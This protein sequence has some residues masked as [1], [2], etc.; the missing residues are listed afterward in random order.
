[1]PGDQ[2]AI[3]MVGSQADSTLLPAPIAQAISLA[4]RSTQLA[5]RVTSIFGTYT[6]STAKFTT[7]SSLELARG[8]VEGVLI[9]AGGETALGSPYAVTDA[10]GILERS[11]EVLHHAVSHAAF[12]TS[13]S[14]QLTGTTLSAV[15][16]VSTLILSSLDQILGSTDSSRAIASIVTLIRREFNNGQE[17]VGV[18]DLVLALSALAYLQGAC[19]KELDSERKTHGSEEIIWDVVVVDDGLRIDVPGTEAPKSPA[20]SPPAESALLGAEDEDERTLERL[21]DEIKSSL[22][23]GTSVT[24]SSSVSTTQTITLD[25]RGPQNVALPTVAGAEIVE[26]TKAN[27]NGP[28]STD[29]SIRVVYKIQRNKLRQTEL[30]HKDDGIVV[31]TPQVIEVDDAGPPSPALSVTTTE[32]SEPRSPTTTRSPAAEQESLAL[33][34]PRSKVSRDLTRPTQASARRSSSAIDHV[35]RR[36]SSPQLASQPVEAAN[37]KRTRMPSSKPVTRATSETSAAAKH[38]KK[39]LPS[40]PKESDKKTGFKQVL[41]GGSQSISNIWNREPSA[42][43]NQGSASRS[44]GKSVGANARGSSSKLQPPPFPRNY[45]PSEQRP[46]SCSGHDVD[47]EQIQRSSSRASYVSVHERRRDSMVSQTDSYSVHAGGDLR[48]ASPSILRTEVR[49]GETRSR[50]PNDHPPSSTSPTMTHHRRNGSHVPSLYSLAGNDSQSSLVLSSYFQKSA[51]RSTDAMRT[52]RQ[53]GAVEGTFPSTHLLR[54]ISRYMRFSSASYGSNFLKLLG[55]SNDMPSLQKGDEPHD[56]IRHFLH[57]TDSCMGNVLLASFVDAGG[58]SDAQGH[59]DSGMPLVHYISL[60]H[61]AKAVVLACR[62]TLGFEDILADLTC[63]YD[64]LQWRGRSH[65]VHKGVLASARRILYGYDGRVLVTLQEALKEFPEYGLV[66]CGHSLGGAVTSLLGVMLSEPNPHGT[67][68][69][70]TTTPQARYMA[71][72]HVDDKLKLPTGRPIHVFAYGPPGAM[73]ATLSKL[74]KGLITTVVHGSDVVPHLSLG[75]LHDFQAMAVAFKKGDNTAKTDIRQ[76]IWQAFQTNVT[77][78]LYNTPVPLEVPDTDLFPALQTLRATLSHEKLLPPG[79]VFALE[80]QR[81][82]RRDAFLFPQENDFGQ[83]ARRMVLTYVKDVEARFGEV[84][85]GTGMLID[86]SP[87][88]YEDALERLRRGVVE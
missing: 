35:Q 36:P 74:T 57:H 53:A 72:N 64:Q 18:T 37:Q 71:G 40:P 31:S 33:P 10:E 42:A 77:G 60:D 41:R 22:N 68:F 88:K 61:E 45:R 23:P 12:W 70:T 47:P 78:R 30:E 83:P 19:R 32:S 46:A 66:L 27:G 85:F 28:D 87:K 4:T 48:P 17:K 49:G 44:Q 15:S 24:I 56:D 9:R 73:S 6:L 80:T 20:T 63:D 7:L 8:I 76:R 84:R 38:K 59:T 82:L 21:K 55:I 1:M 2:P 11:L 58:G 5:I 81:V 13:A 86:H 29:P 25:V 34:K 3:A 69:V 79:E 67:G 62:G 16:D 75:L 39:A 52:L 54:N 43:S 14:F 51:Y 50:Q 65:R 26:A